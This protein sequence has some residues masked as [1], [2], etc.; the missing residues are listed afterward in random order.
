MIYS[1]ENSRKC[2]KL[3][4]D[5]LITVQ[6][7]LDELKRLLGPSLVTLPVQERKLLGKIE[8]Q[9]IDFLNLSLEMAQSNPEL[10]PMYLE[11]SGFQEKIILTCELWQIIKKIDSL[12]ESINDINTLIG[13]DV[14]ENALMFYSNVRIAA[15]R[16]IPGARAIYDELKTAFPSRKK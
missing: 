2:G 7:K 12:R 16:D 8:S 9:T 5:L 3:S 6:A 11:I 14:M 15:R 1:M 10:F 13:C 4:R